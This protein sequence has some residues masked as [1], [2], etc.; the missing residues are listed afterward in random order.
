MNVKTVD[1]HSSHAS[2][3]LA[4]SLRNTGFAVLVN[5]PI[6]P[7]RIEEIYSSWAAFF[8]MHPSMTG[9][10]ILKNRMDFFLFNPNMPRAPLLRI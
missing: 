6:T 3:D 1:Y 2:A 8:L 5:H 9:F 10:V 4:E 7:Q